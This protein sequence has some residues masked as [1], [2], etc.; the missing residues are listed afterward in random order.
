MR[1]I[2]TGDL[3]IKEK[4]DQQTN[5]KVFKFINEIKE[6]NADLL[7][8]AGDIV[9]SGLEDDYYKAAEIFE[10]LSIEK[11][12]IPGNRDFYNGGNV[13]FSACFYDLESA[14]DLPEDP[15]T[16]RRNGDRPLIID[17][18]YILVGICTPR[19]DLSTGV[20]GHGQ[21]RLTENIFKEYGINK[22][23]ILVMHHHLLPIPIGGLEENIINDVGDI[24]RMISDSSIDL[25]LT[26]HQHHPW[27]SEYSSG[28]HNKHYT[29]ILTCGSPTMDDPRGFRFNSYN[30]IDVDENSKK[31]NNAYVKV[32]TGSWSKEQMIPM[33]EF[34]KIPPQTKKDFMQSEFAHYL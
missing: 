13:C 6:S 19:R 2:H 15:M 21:K 16:Q 31:L 10:M 3:N 4:M 23:K 17:K 18:E 22:Y 1:I 20:I 11:V 30:V 25:V 5:E 29:T 33:N 14:L 12:F 8:V 32:L 7:V 24:I 9:E 28:V 26:G 27:A 34:V